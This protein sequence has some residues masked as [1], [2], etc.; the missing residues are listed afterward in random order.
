MNILFVTNFYPPH[1]V[2]GYEQWCHE[3]AQILSTRGHQ[4]CSLTSRY[5]ERGSRIDERGV[6]VH[7]LLNLE[8]VGGLAKSIRALLLTRRRNEKENFVII[9]ELV[10]K[11]NLGLTQ[12]NRE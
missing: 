3:V 1:S 6:Q 8:V 12:L 5:G 2:G 4:V 11:I 9:S 7:R 10:N